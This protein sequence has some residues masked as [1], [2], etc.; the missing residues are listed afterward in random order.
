MKIRSLAAALIAPLVLLAAST[1]RAA[2]ALSLG[3]DYLL[4]GVSV[5]ERETT[6]PDLSYYDQ[7]LRAY[8]ITDLSKDVEATVRVQSIT[9]WGNENSS[10]TLMT[11]YPDSNGRFWVENAFVRLPN[12]WQDRIVATIG[13][14]P[15][16]WGDGLILSDDELGFNAIRLQV[17]SPLRFLPVDLD[18]FT[19]KITETLQAD[20]DTDLHG[21]VIGFDRN[22]TRWEIMGLMEQSRNPGSYEAGAETAPITATD[23][24]RSIYGVRARLNLKDAFMKGEY[25][26]QSGNV[27]RPGGNDINL[28]GDAYVIGL[29]GK[30]NT[31]R[32]GRFG[33]LLEYA[34]GSGDDAT[35]PGDDESFR[36]TFAHR[37]SGLERA[38]WGRYAA[39]TFS[40]IRSSTAPFANASSSNDG[41]PPGT[42]GIQTINFA[43][44]ATPWSQWTFSFAYLT[45]KAQKN[46]VGNKQLG[47]EFDYGVEYRYS[48]LVTMRGSY[49]TFIPKAAFDPVTKTKASMS[50]FEVDLRF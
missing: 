10:S 3:A 18:A 25:Y 24:S 40:D 15:I 4:R 35:T 29:G 36:P 23:I 46:L 50:T 34:A 28:K 8:L 44:D 20:V 45:F 21:A 37:W 11:R 12:I 17:K 30:Q 32:W 47:T 49:S 2:N 7:Q 1:A 41:L 16:R 22:L 31:A 39:A 6:T 48:G 38:G 5:S 19:A 26:I 27:E 14:Q 33:A 43:I 42:S 13:R 9:P